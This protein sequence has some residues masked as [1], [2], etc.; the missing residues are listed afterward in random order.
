MQSIKLFT[1]ND[2][3]VA[4][5]A[6][7]I[8]DRQITFDVY[9]NEHG[10]FALLIVSGSTV[11]AQT[12]DKLHVGGLKEFFI[13]RIQRDAFNTYLQKY[14]GYLSKSQTISLHDKAQ[15]IY[16]SARGVIKNLF[17]TP[18]SPQA[19]NEGKKIALHIMD[20]VLSEPRAFLLLL[21]VSSYDYYTYT[22]SINVSLYAIGIGKYLKLPTEQISY[23]AKAGILHD[24]GKSKIS[25]DIINKPGKLTDEEFEVMK[26]HPIYSH[27]IL[28]A[29]GETS[30]EI[31]SG[32][33]HHH[34]KRN[35]LGYPDKLTKDQIS[36]TAQV[37]AVADIFDALTTRRSYKDACPTFAAL[38]LMRER[39]TEHINPEIFTA[40]VHCMHGELH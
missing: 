21:Q 26:S 22:H 14:L 40:F 24:L 30:A 8:P 23:L 27:D 6:C 10:Q 7:L 16:S 35:G 12:L 37:L 13:P 19:L 9:I 2:F 39:M 31:L 18:E 25:G 33:K 36:F 4:P 20:K 34:E 38:R 29:Q 17:D 3:D 5:I 28:V 15:I 32:V 11:Q 1:H